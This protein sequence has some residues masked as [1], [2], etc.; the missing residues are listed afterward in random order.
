LCCSFIDNIHPVFGRVVEGMDV[1]DEI[2]SVETDAND[3]PIESVIIEKA[4]LV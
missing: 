4:E 2:A 3:K 1:V